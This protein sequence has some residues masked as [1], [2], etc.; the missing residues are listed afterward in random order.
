MGISVKD[1]SA[2]AQK[3][4]T[5]AAAAQPEFAAGVKGSGSKWQ[6]ATA[7]SG[8]NYEA[9]VQAAIG[10]KAFQKGVA[11]SGGDY[12]AERAST[13]GARRFAE[14]VREGA[15][16][17]AEGFKPFGDALASVNLPPRGPK[18]DPRNMARATTVAE[19]L[20]RKKVGG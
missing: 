3:F 19:A 5:R 4:G 16:N 14:G 6:A 9:G 10:R 2:S 15:G 1:L 13:I 7:S 18:G 20:R 8:E 12:F 11:A 17:W